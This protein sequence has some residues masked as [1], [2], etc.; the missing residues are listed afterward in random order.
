MTSAVKGGKSSYPQ[1][2][3]V[4]YIV[5]LS[6][7]A[8]EAVARKLPWLLIQQIIQP[9]DGSSGVF[10]RI[11]RLYMVPLIFQR[12]FPAYFPVF[13]PVLPAIM[14]DALV[15]LRRGRLCIFVNDNFP[16]KARMDIRNSCIHASDTSSLIVVT[17]YSILILKSALMKCRRAFR[18]R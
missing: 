18:Y 17:N 3:L 12:I 16:F 13:F 8:A 6:R 5:N 7:A 11:S 9:S 10:M 4:V 2:V 1:I 15:Y 14:A